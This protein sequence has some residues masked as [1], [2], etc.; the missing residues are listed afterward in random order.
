MD[1]EENQHPNQVRRERKLI[2]ILAIVLFLCIGFYVYSLIHHTGST[3]T[4]TANVVL[5]KKNHSQIKKVNLGKKG[6][7]KADAANSKVDRPFVTDFI[8]QYFAFDEMK[9]QQHVKDV[10]K[11]LTPAFYKALLQADTNDT[12]RK[13]YAYR[14]VEHV[15]FASVK[16]VGSIERYTATMTCQLYSGQKKKTAKTIMDI[17]VDVSKRQGKTIVSNFAVSGKHVIKNE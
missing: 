14:K 12:H 16:K 5:I 17:S 8:T 13:P 7:G 1:N 4:K 6:T 2:I 3:H 9:P 11:D 15:T 10:R